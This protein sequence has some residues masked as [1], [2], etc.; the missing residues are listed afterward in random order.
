MHLYVMIR[1]AAIQEEM[2]GVHENG[3]M[4]SKGVEKLKGRRGSRR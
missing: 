1:R 2:R 3:K 4:G